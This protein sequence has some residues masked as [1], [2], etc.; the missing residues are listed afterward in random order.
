MMTVTLTTLTQRK[1][2]M[3]LQPINH[4][5]THT[6]KQIGVTIAGTYGAHHADAQP[7][8]LFRVAQ[9]A[10]PI[11]AV[12]QRVAHGGPENGGDLLLT[13]DGVQGTNGER[14]L[15]RWQKQGGIR[16]LQK[17]GHE[18][19]EW[20]EKRECIGNDARL[21]RMRNHGENGVLH[22]TIGRRQIELDLRQDLLKKGHFLGG[23]FLLVAKLPPFEETVHEGGGFLLLIGD[24]VEQKPHNWDEHLKHM[25][26][27]GRQQT[28]ADLYGI[29]CEWEEGRVVRI[30][31][32]FI[33]PNGGKKGQLVL[34][35]VAAKCCGHTKLNQHRVHQ[36]VAVSGSE[37][38]NG[39]ELVMPTEP[40]K[41]VR[42]QTV[43]RVQR[44]VEEEGIKKR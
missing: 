17:R 16:G 24:T 43:V 5:L 31:R 13:G 27:L 4:L 41:G 39:V 6:L 38:F 40:K 2:Q 20:G 3:S 30:H 34:H 22:T 23:R 14:T 8:R 19:Q 10:P 11:V 36:I 35:G 33:P 26:R 21:K 25:Q 18:G 44:P 7:R 42:D 32:G 28:R 9:L 1:L 37:C 29:L 12:L 15:Q